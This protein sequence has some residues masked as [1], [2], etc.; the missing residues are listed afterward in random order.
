MHGLPLSPN[1]NSWDNPLICEDLF[2][3]FSVS[4]FFF[5]LSRKEGA[6]SLAPPGWLSLVTG[7][8][9]NVSV[10]WYPLVVNYLGCRW[11][12]PNKDD[13]TQEQFY[14]DPGG[15]LMLSG[16]GSRNQIEFRLIFGSTGLL[17]KQV[18]VVL[19]LV[20]LSVDVTVGWLHTPPPH[21]TVLHQQML[22]GGAIWHYPS[23]TIIPGE[24][25]E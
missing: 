2:S 20:S 7:T 14:T 16:C 6:W 23:V 24:P 8:G 21:V 22:D 17:V 15:L 11:H 4:G 19:H 9:R 13:S 18:R 25:M 5:Y 3:I 12:I 1:C 10:T